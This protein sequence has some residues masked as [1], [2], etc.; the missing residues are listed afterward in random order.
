MQCSCI[1]GNY[2]FEITKSECS[3]MIYTD[4]S[5]WMDDE[6]YTVPETYTVVIT[7]PDSKRPTQLE[8]TTQGVTEI[9]FGGS[10]LPDGVYC[11]Q[12][13]SCGVT[14]TRY[15]AYTCTAE[16]KVSNVLAELDIDDDHSHL[17]EITLHLEAIHNFA[18][19]GQNKSAEK[20]Y[21]IVKKLLD[22]LNCDC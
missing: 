9:S 18:E 1:R 14:Y 5:Q 11:F 19:N 8:V 12:V 17:T 16:C 21:K 6:G 7:R 10:C 4:L 20:E 2:N 15:K 3:K 22:R 13:E